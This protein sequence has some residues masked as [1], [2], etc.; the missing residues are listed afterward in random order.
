MNKYI[1]FLPYRHKEV[2]YL[3]NREQKGDFQSPSHYAFDQQLEIH[4]IAS[5]S[6]AICINSIHS[7]TSP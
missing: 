5:L 3:L 7:A 4:E 6:I 2:E 1:L